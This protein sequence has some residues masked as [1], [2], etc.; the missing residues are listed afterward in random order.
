MSLHPAQRPTVLCAWLLAAALLAPL[1]PFGCGPG[2]SLDAIRAQQERGQY[3]ETIEPLRALLR[4][5][6][7]DPEVNYLYARALIATQR[8]SL[9]TWALRK[10]MEDPNWTVKAALQLANA[11][12]M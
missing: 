4:E 5:K 10:A 8:P 2:K 3:D 1:A 7:D 6:P 9:A 11:A 12:L